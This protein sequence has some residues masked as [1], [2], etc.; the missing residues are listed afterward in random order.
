MSTKKK[1]IP[2]YLSLTYICELSHQFIIIL[3]PFS[4]FS[5]FFRHLKEKK[6]T[7]TN[8]TFLVVDQYFLKNSNRNMFDYRTI[9]M[10]S[11]KQIRKNTKKQI[12]M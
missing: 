5:M 10:H 1:N 6:S 7:N 3:L 4:C 12:L 11:K 9:C 2:I 8:I